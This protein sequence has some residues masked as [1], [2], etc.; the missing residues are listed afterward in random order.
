MS[1][2]H[3][4]PFFEISCP[5][6]FDH[7]LGDVD[8]SYVGAAGVVHVLAEFG[9][10]TPHDQGLAGDLHVLVEDVTE[11]SVLTIPLERCAP[12]G[13]ELVPVALQL[14]LGVGDRQQTHVGITWL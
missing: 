14:E 5:H 6:L 4:C 9:V 10:A 2:R 3:F 8:V 7:D 12:F 11:V 13:E 1:E